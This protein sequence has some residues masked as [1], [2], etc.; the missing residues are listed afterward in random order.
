M[1]REEA[2][3]YWKGLRKTFSSQLEKEENHFGRM[4]LQ[5]TIDAIDMAIS[6]LRQQGVP[7]KDVGTNDPLTLDD[8]IAHLDDTLSDTG[9]KWSC[10]S[11]RME[12]VQLRAWLAE[13][14]DIKQERNAPLTMDE[15][16]Q[17]DGEPVWVSVSNIWRESGVSEGWC[18]VR[19]H[20]EDDRVRVYVYDTRHGARFFAQQDYGASWIAHRQKPEE[21]KHETD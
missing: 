10:E 19:F 16:R 12:H 14:R 21:D 7:Y 4:H 8:A 15:L 5:T 6:A 11:C 18:I 3:E 9:R 1:T 20:S 13:L 17:M 2:I